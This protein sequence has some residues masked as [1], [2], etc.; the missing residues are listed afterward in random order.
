MADS[1]LKKSTITI[2][3]TLKSQPISKW[4][5][6]ISKITQIKKRCCKTHC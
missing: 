5:V 2:M 3:A 4:K 6:K 1:P